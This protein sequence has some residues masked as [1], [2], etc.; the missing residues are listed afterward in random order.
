MSTRAEEGMKAGFSL[1]LVMKQGFVMP[2]GILHHITSMKDRT[3]RDDDIFVCTY[4]KSGTHWVWE[5]LNMVVAGKAEYAKHW[6]NSAFYESRT[7]DDLDT[8]PS[9]RI[10]FTHLT[11]DLL[12][13][14]IWNRKCHV[15]NVQR[16]PKDAVVSFFVQ[17]TNQNWVDK[18]RDPAFVG[19][20]DNYVDAHIK[21]NVP[22][23]SV[24]EHSLRWNRFPKEHPDV[25]FLQVQFED[26]KEDAVREVRRLAE[27]IKR[28]L[29]DD[30][31]E[32]IADACSFSKLKYAS[33]NIKDQTFHN[34]WREGSS[35]YFRKGETG[36][37]K[38]WF[39]VA[40]SER[41]DAVYQQLYN[42]PFPY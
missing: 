6:Q 37:W 1:Q 18:S 32:Q 19:S 15:V 39:T 20:W 2:A 28:P 35:G 11:P 42:H 27:F 26:L 36:D 13:Q 12:P 9:P 8:L 40:Q 14:D 16:N 30:V 25:P 23:D 41:F 10:I 5:I 21:G 3:V 29:S 17:H 22:F 4:P 33:E 34:R 31:Y 7:E 38:N 24:L